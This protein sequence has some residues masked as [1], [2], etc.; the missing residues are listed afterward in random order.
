MNS[1]PGTFFWSLIVHLELLLHGRVD[2]G[3]CGPGELCHQL[4]IDG[5]E[6]LAQGVDKV[7]VQKSLLALLCPVLGVVLD[8]N[9]R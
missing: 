3:A 1:N 5:F 9:V 4:V 7:S 6:A 8:V 2:E